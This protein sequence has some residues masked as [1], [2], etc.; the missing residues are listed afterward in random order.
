GAQ[1]HL[2]NI[3]RCSI[4]VGNGFCT[5]TAYNVLV[6]Q[7]SCPTACKM[8]CP[9]T[10]STA[11][12]ACLGDANANCAAWAAKAADPFCL[13]TTFA[14][15]S[16][17]LYCCRT[18]AAEITP[19]GDCVIYNNARVRVSSLTNNAAIQAVPAGNTLFR[20]FVRSGCRL[21]LFAEA[22][23]APATATPLQTVTGSTMFQA[24]QTAAAG[25]LGVVCSCP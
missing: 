22:T 24:V 19:V 17:F 5:N 4:W 9:N 20:T 11:V 7:A 15:S 1:N 18:C 8:G 14:S 25:A 23:A 13:S 16:K 2:D 6:K 21:R 3:F 12:D 10:P